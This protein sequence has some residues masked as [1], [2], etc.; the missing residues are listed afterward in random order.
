M[1]RTKEDA[2]QTREKLLDAA[3][4]LFARQGVAH[5]CMQDIAQAASLTRGAVYWHFKDKGDLFNAM[6]DRAV[7]P[8]EEAVGDLTAR[9]WDD[10]L[11]QVRHALLG[12]LQLIT[13]DERTRRVLGIATRKIE[14]VDDMSSVR[15]R[16]LA[17]HLRCRQHIEG[18][19][20]LAR[21]RG[22]IKPEPVARAVAVSLTA[23]IHGLIDLWMLEPA[24]FPL[25]DSGQQALDLYLAA[26]RVEGPAATDPSVASSSRSSPSR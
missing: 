26:L 14:F 5:T 11:A 17:V 1:R 21:S 25:V 23:T 10:P 12:A 2:L 9:P 20:E 19:I 22:L 4:C 24:L 15:E 18:A 13:D 7:L 16:H 8:M 6:M 3:E